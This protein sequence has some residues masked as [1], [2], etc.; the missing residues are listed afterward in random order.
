MIT[1]IVSHGPGALE[2][3]PVCCDG[4]EEGTASKACMYS[5]HKHANLRT[6]PWPLDWMPMSCGSERRRV[7][8]YQRRW[9]VFWTGKQACGQVTIWKCFSQMLF[10]T[11]LAL[12]FF[13]SSGIRWRGWSNSSTRI[14]KWLMVVSCK[15][16]HVFSEK[17]RKP[18]RE[19][20]GMAKPLETG[21]V[22]DLSKENG[23]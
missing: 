1:S 4:A 6:D 8:M 13:Q 18:T 17:I 21:K 14:W 16:G 5:K 23:L 12:G 7:R 11:I 10:I 2:T 22:Y 3:G 15:F 20:A 19:F 9:I